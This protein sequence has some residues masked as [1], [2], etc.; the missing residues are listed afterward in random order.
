MMQ[1]R[2]MK[3]ALLWLAVTLAAGLIAYPATAQAAS[4]AGGRLTS[5]ATDASDDVVYHGGSVM[6]GDMKAYLIFWEPA[7]APR[8]PPVR[9]TLETV[10]P[11]RRRLRALREQPAVHRRRRC[12]SHRRHPGRSIPRHQAVS[13]RTSAGR[14]RPRRDRS[15][16]DSQGLDARN[17]PRLL[18]LHVPGRIHLHTLRDM[19]G[20]PEPILLVPLRLSHA[21]RSGALRGN[22]VRRELPDGL[23]RTNSQPQPRHRRRRRGEP[24][25][26]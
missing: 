25:L 4:D 15:G 12:G 20:A 10:L 13:R 18:R 26:P 1:G 17:H 22:A 19:H 2:R 8:E 5:A 24:H 14:R 9:A 7:G 16:H 3:A 23:L 21:R 11:R 6:A